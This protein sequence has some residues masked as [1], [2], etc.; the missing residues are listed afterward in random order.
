MSDSDDTDLLL[1]IPPDFFLVQT[2]DLDEVDSEE[3]FLLRNNQQLVEQSVVNGLIT[4]VNELE[5]R[6][7]LIESLDSSRLSAL[8]NNTLGLNQSYSG[9]NSHQTQLLLAKV[10]DYTNY[11]SM[12][13]SVHILSGSI[14]SIQHNH[15]LKSRND[16]GSPPRPRQ[17]FSLPSTPTNG[18]Y[19]RSEFQPSRLNH[20]EIHNPN[21]VSMHLE[22]DNNKNIIDNARSERL[23]AFEKQNTQAP[24]SNFYPN[25][26][27]YDENHSVILNSKG[28][29]EE[30][31]LLGEIDQYLSDVERHG[32]IFK[33]KDEELHTYAL[34]DPFI[35]N[36]LK[37][38]DENCDNLT[39]NENNS[40]KKH[41]DLPEVDRLLKEMEAT[42]NE[43]EQKLKLHNPPKRTVN[44]IPDKTTY[45]SQIGEN[46]GSIPD[47]G[48]GLKEFCSN[49]AN[50]NIGGNDERSYPILIEE[51]FV[52]KNVLLLGENDKKMDYNSV[53]NT[54]SVVDN[55]FIQTRHSPSSRRRLD[56]DLRYKVIDKQP[57]LIN[58][59]RSH[60]QNMKKVYK[61]T[62]MVDLANAQNVFM[63]STQ[64]FESQN[65]QPSI[66]KH[67]SPTKFN[68]SKHLGLDSLRD[69]FNSERDRRFQL[70][71]SQETA[72]NHTSSQKSGYNSQSNQSRPMD[73]RKKVSDDYLSPNDVKQQA[74]DIPLKHDKQA[75]IIES[76]KNYPSLQKP[77]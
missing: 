36:G 52:K 67:A 28:I 75:I 62:N 32:G 29:P 68:I 53:I 39:S 38:M 45:Y 51:P 4:H 73:L 23:A 21:N 64:G 58:N 12:S 59:Y 57:P 2:S 22:N 63:K 60:D 7:C 49:D 30:K 42:Q 71:Q 24:K 17:P 27:V 44:T 37:I 16:F 35:G 5:D 61:P 10:N 54:S 9:S 25:L 41:L 1:L 6:I 8:D 18:A 47:L 50:K 3:N 74:V 65:Q 13:D 34:K 43:I 55:S 56:M 69:K 66:K 77:R 48:F 26:A 33:N 19:N 11:N 70:I 20:K 40:V 14:D 46:S 31:E 72:E 76:C 15:Y